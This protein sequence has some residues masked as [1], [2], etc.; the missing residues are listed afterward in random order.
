VPGWE[1]RAVTETLNVRS[2]LVP[3]ELVAATDIVPPVE[4]GVADMDVEA[5]LPLHPEGNVHI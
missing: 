3:H 5:E 2:E 4:P 1:G